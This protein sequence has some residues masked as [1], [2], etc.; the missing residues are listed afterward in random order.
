MAGFIGNATSAFYTQQLGDSVIDNR[1]MPEFFVDTDPFFVVRL[2]ACFDLFMGYETQYWP[3]GGRLDTPDD[4]SL[5]AIKWA[6][7]E[8]IEPKGGGT[9]SRLAIAGQCLDVNGTPVPG[10]VVKLFKTANTPMPGKDSLFDEVVADNNGNWVLYTPYYPD[11]FYVVEYK[12]G[13][14]VPDIFGTTVNT[15]TGV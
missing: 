5:S 10:A 12:L 7:P 13:S 6:S 2:A 15:L 11:T 8:L 4:A 3:G 9:T 1:G 14:T